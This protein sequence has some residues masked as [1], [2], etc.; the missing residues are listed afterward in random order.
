MN[1]GRHLAAECSQI[2]LSCRVCE[3]F[4]TNLPSVGCYSPSFVKSKK[5]NSRFAS[6]NWLG[7]IAGNHSWGRATEGDGR[8]SSRGV[9]TG[10]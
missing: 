1:F 9:D 7:P 3:S 5:R 8:I 4:G 2:C 6:G 10:S